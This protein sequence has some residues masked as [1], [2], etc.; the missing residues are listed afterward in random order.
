MKTRK[1]MKKKL[2]LKKQTISNFNLVARDNLD[3]VKGGTMLP[4]QVITCVVV[5]LTIQYSCDKRLE[6]CNLPVD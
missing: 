6:I 1:N 2:S 5:T 4:T 3:K